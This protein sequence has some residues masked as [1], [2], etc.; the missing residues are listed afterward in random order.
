VKGEAKLRREALKYYSPAAA[1]LSLRGLGVRFKKATSTEGALEWLSS[2]L[3]QGRFGDA[4]FSVSPI[5]L[6]RFQ[7]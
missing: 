6:A 7:R 1:G 5:I 2:D 4:L 3:G